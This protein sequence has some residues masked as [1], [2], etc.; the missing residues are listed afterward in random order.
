[1]PHSTKV[2][3]NARPSKVIVFFLGSEKV[4]VAEER[5]AVSRF[6]KVALVAIAVS[7]GQG[8]EC[9]GSSFKNLVALPTS[10]CWGNYPVTAPAIRS[11]AVVCC[12]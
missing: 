8:S 12:K 1:M 11:S 3:V 2:K 7:T 6:K 5:V 10:G 4:A 9:S